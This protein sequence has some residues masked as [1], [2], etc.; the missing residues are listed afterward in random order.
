MSLKSIRLRINP[1]QYQTLPLWTWLPPFFA[2]LFVAVIFTS[3]RNI[4][5]FYKIN[6][7]SLL[8]GK[9][10]WANITILGDSL[11]AAVLFFPW[12]RRH[13][14]LVWAAVIS[15]IIALLVSHGLKNFLHLPRP[16]AVLPGDTFQIIGPV[17][18]HRSFPS[19]HA[20]TVFTLLGIWILSSASIAQRWMLLVTGMIIALSRIVV[21]V[22]W[23]TDVLAGMSI[24]WISAVAGIKLNQHIPWGTKPA[25]YNVF[26]SV[27]VAAAFVSMFLYKT[28]Y[29]NVFIFQILIAAGCI[30]I[31]LSDHLH[32]LLKVL[33][34][35]FGIKLIAKS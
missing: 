14:E 15:S 32:M 29:S 1:Y 34:T 8:T 2:L 7:L 31:F 10:F 3:S 35:W 25:A 21:G 16:A 28:G 9:D 19:G 20:T 5:L 30:L 4:E 26:L 22:H 13:P 12:I 24:G 23:P 11:I 27:I 17:F 18:K 33:E 6:S